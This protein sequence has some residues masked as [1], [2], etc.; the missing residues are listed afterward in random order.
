MSTNLKIEKKIENQI[1][2][3][4]KLKWFYVLGLNSWGVMKS[5]KCKKTGQ[6]KKY[7]LR[8][9]PKGTPDIVSCINWKFVWVEVKK[10]QEEISKFWRIVEKYR[11]K[12]FINPFDKPRELCQYEKGVEIDKAGGDFYVVCSLDQFI[13]LLK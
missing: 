7:M 10:N 11:D 4:M 2:D 3:R 6:M 9:C 13:S 8:L 1:I 12:K 5:Y